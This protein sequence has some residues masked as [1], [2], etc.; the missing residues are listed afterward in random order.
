MKFKLFFLFLCFGAMPYLAYGQDNVKKKIP[1]M[2][3]HLPAANRAILHS[4][5]ASHHNLF[6]KTLCFKQNCRR[7]MSWQRAQ[8][9]RR[10]NDY[11]NVP[12]V[13]NAKKGKKQ[14]THAV[15]HT[16]EP[17]APLPDTT[18]LKKQVAPV[19]D[20]S[21]P[22]E[23][24]FILSDVLFDFNSPTLKEDFTS[25]LDTLVDILMKKTSIQVMIIGH[26][27]NTGREAYNQ[28]LS[29]SR[30]EAVGLY[31]IDKGISPYRIQFEGRG[32]SEPIGDNTFEE[33]RQKNRRVEIILRE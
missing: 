4:K 2:V 7:A 3:S 24:R 11:K 31:L 26:T 28:R 29:T 20:K 6:Q 16:T 30:A 10:F 12:Q 32:S 9:K 14:D 1:T 8:K 19:V 22:V 21:A 17:P 5:N 25:R 27:D 13:R 18:Q 15:N 33:G 23:T